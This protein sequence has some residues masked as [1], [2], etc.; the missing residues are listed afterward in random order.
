M[1]YVS[2]N[3][4]GDLYEKPDRFDIHRDPE[5]QAF[6]GGGRHSCLGMALA[7]LELK[8]LFEE[9]LKRYPNMTRAG[10]PQPAVSQFLNQLKTLPVRLNG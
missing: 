4:D 7:R 1:W 2:S 9:V 6:G 5:H 8:I 3:R 10:D